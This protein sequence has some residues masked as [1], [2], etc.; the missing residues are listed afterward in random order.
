MRSERV[1]GVACVLALLCG[2]P[3]EA[4]DGMRVLMRLAGAADRA[5]LPRV[6]GQLSDV[7]VELIAVETP[8]LEQTFAEQVQAAHALAAER[9]GDVVLWFA[10]SEAGFL[11]HVAT[12]GNERILTRRLADGGKIDSG[13][14]EKTALA[15]RS[16]VTAL[17]AGGGIGVSTAEALAEA[18]PA[19]A[20]AREE[21]V[22][23]HVERG[24]F[25]DQVEDQQAPA[26]ERDS[27][28]PALES[29]LTQS[30]PLGARVL[31]GLQGVVD[32]Q[33]ALGQQGLYARAGLSW[34]AFALQMYGTASLPARIEDPYFTL[35]IA[36]H[37]A[38]AALSFRAQ[39]TR[40]ASVWLGGHAGAL[41][42]S[43]SSEAKSSAV[44]AA[45][46][47]LTAAFTSGP[48]LGVDWM[49]GRY[50]L[51]V[52]LGLDVLPSAPRFES[53]G[54]SSLGAR[55]AHRLWSVEPRLGIGLEA[56]LP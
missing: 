32:G 37:S 12:P 20:E 21:R 34:G 30:A 33:S 42:L 29:T 50:G 13:L 14:M 36:R 23:V 56:A 22:S 15:V 28:E 38:G 46:R 40:D 4:Q 11:V 7:S 2:A 49:F 26:P 8:P 48:E 24:A 19:E 10:S 45:P 55:D 5:L 41:L 52:L 31:I 9:S 6:R 54:V 17:A 53:A 3:A 25:Q 43:R 35:H 27:L 51:G 1:V 47:S 39:L 16:A 18:A 44:L